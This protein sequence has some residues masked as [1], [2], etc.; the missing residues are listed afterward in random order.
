MA[1]DERTDEAR[2]FTLIELLI[3]VAVIGVIAT[4]LIPNL[5]DALQKAKQRATVAQ[6]KATGEAWFS[7]LTDEVSAAGAGSSQTFTFS[8]L[9][10]KLTADELLDVLFDDTEFFYIRDVPTNDGWGHPFD[11]AWSG[12]PLSARVMGVRSRG[13]DGL[14][15]PTGEPYTL[16]PF[17]SSRY[18]EDIVWLDGFFIRYPSGARTQ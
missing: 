17:T 10:E 18:D 1:R 14:V 15:G 12:N 11:Y 4:I 5:L 9:S 3:V 2:G 6:I 7:W 16:G 13:R 8:T